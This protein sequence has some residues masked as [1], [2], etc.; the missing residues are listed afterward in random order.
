MNFAEA[1][2]Y[3]AYSLQV[4]EKALIQQAMEAWKEQKIFET[5]EKLMAVLEIYPYS[6]EAN[7]RLA[8]MFSVLE[9]NISE[10]KNK[11]KLNKIRKEYLEVVDGILDSITSSGDGASKETSFK[12]INI[13]EEYWT[14][15]SLGYRVTE[16]ELIKDSDGV[17]DKFLV[18]NSEGKKSEVYFDI[19]K[20]YKEPSNQSVEL[21]E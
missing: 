8:D 21:T 4:I 7:R 15:A 10:K 18:A 1:E 6:I 20:F 2:D 3:N 9:G 16:Q 13:Q 19:S 12:V 17:Y 14:I 5:Q 11:K